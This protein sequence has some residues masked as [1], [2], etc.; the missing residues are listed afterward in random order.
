MKNTLIYYC[1]Y[2]V[3]I[4]ACIIHIYF[5]DFSFQFDANCLTAGISKYHDFYW[6]KTNMQTRNNIKQD[7]FICCDISFMN[8]IGYS[9]GMTLLTHWLVLPTWD[10]SRSGSSMNTWLHW[11]RWKLS[12]NK[13]IFV[14]CNNFQQVMNKKKLVACII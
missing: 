1:C 9:V 10:S 5:S 13:Y 3:S 7:G 2:L 6:I 12:S 14:S 11:P 8:A 4:S